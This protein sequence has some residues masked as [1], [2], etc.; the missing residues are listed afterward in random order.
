MIE[1]ISGAA[2]GAVVG[3]VAKDKLMA[4]NVQN[5]AQ[6]QEMD[7]LYAENEKLRK[8]AKELERQVEDLM[9]SVDRNRRDLKNRENDH[10]DM[11]DELDNSKTEIKKLRRLNQALTAQVEEYKAACSIYESELNQFKKNK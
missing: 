3:V 6:K 9:A 5:N 8:R 4:N 10:E 7:T 2:I 11:E 1:F